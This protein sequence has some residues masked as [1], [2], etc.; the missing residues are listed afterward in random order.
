LTAPEEL[1]AEA[2]ENKHRAVVEAYKN[3]KLAFGF[4]AGGL[5]FPYYGTLWESILAASA[6]Q[7][8][9][10]D[11]SAIFDNLKGMARPLTAG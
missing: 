7:C 8:T 6:N 9:C 10:L 5:L 4:S 2:L 1:A 3:G 11:R